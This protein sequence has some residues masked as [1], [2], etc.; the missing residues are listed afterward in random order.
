MIISISLIVERKSNI[1]TFKKSVTRQAI[2]RT[3]PRGTSHREYYSEHI[4][5][6]QHNAVKMAKN[7]AHKSG[8]VE[9][10]KFVKQIYLDSAMK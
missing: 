4:Y 1:V 6:N 9:P 8:K 10:N 3:F 5:D 7:D 2:T